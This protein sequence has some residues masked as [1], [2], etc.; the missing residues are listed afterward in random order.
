MGHSFVC[1]DIIYCDLVLLSLSKCDT[2]T[3]ING[4][5]HDIELF[6]LH[7][8]CGSFMPPSWNLSVQNENNSD[9]AVVHHLQGY[10]FCELVDG[11]LTDHVIQ[12]LNCRKIGNKSLTVKR[13]AE[14]TK[15]SSPLL[16]T[17]LGSPPPAQ[18][19]PLQVKNTPN[20]GMAAM[21]SFGFT[22]PPVHSRA[23]GSLGISGMMPISKS[24]MRNIPAAQGGARQALQQV[25]VHCQDMADAISQ[26]MIPAGHGN[27]GMD[28]AGVASPKAQSIGDGQLSSMV[29]PNSPTIPSNS[30]GFHL[31]QDMGAISELGMFGNLPPA[32]GLQGGCTLLNT[33]TDTGGMPCMMGGMEMT[34][35]SLSVF[36][37]YPSIIRQGIHN[38]GSAVLGRGEHE[39]GMARLS[40][41]W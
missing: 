12:Q 36:R 27:S 7:P 3:K 35:E 25:G 34:D 2:C 38:H 4:R 21:S 5:G 18:N 30:S 15:S 23:S 40:A 31:N 13:A 9:V 16:T 20:Y 39:F 24:T 29:V 6:R 17:M 22:Y 8:S 1:F 14:G 41:L 26:P 33:G 32:S 19:Y 10:A 28:G 11:S 37:R